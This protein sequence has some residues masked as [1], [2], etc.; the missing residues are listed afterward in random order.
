MASVYDW[1]SRRAEMERASIESYQP[2]TPDDP[3]FTGSR[4]CP[5]PPRP[6]PRVEESQA[7][8][9]KSPTLPASAFADKCPNTRA[10]GR[11]LHHARRSPSPR[12]GVFLHAMSVGPC[13]GPL[14]VHLLTTLRFVGLL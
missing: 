6:R 11:A 14:A 10:S 7:E 4:D 1:F 2:D 12:M 9:S 13:L 5:V 8:P 3:D